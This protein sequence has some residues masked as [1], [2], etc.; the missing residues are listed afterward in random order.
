MSKFFLPVPAEFKET[1]VITIDDEYDYPDAERAQEEKNEI[2]SYVIDIN[3]EDTQEITVF[4]DRE[5]KKITFENY[6]DWFVTMFQGTIEQPYSL[7]DEDGGILTAYSYY[8]HEANQM[9]QM[10]LL[11]DEAQLEK[12]KDFL[13][14]IGFTFDKMPVDKL[15]N[16]NKD[17]FGNVDNAMPLIVD[18]EDHYA[19]NAYD[20]NKQRMHEMRIVFDYSQYNSV[21]T[22]LAQ[23]N[24]NL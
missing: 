15:K 1:L 20:I 3:D 5:I 16:Y 22:M 13:V 8:N 18:G 7:L 19:Y 10:R 14:Q 12:V 24:F 4:I 2:N 21:V 6:I 23:G 17:L 9:S 11:F